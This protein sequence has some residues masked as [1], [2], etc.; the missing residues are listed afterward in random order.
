MCSPDCAED[1]LP[2]SPLIQPANGASS[3]LPAA[4]EGKP[5]TAETLWAEFILSFDQT[6]LQDRQDL[7][8]NTLE[9][10]FTTSNEAIR[11]LAEELIKRSLPAIHNEACLYRIASSRMSGPE[12]ATWACEMYV[13]LPHQTTDDLEALLLKTTLSRN[14]RKGVA[15]RLLSYPDVALDA[16]EIIERDFAELFTATNRQRLQCMRKRLA[17]LGEL[18]DR[19][20]RLGPGKMPD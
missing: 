9:L 4:D 18:F 14:V 7:V 13:K 20:D 15:N 1:H 10:Y 19:L 17:Y 8:D 6:L 16:L 3:S 11:S 2:E 5:V 12:F